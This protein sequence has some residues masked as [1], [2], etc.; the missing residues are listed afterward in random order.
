MAPE[1][2]ILFPE[3]VEAYKKKKETKKVSIPKLDLG[4]VRELMNY[5]KKFVEAELK[6]RNNVPKTERIRL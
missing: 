2:V 1:L 6:R 5:N 4:K 3:K